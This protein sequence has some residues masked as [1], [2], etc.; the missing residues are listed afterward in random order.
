MSLPP[1]V[2]GLL[3]GATEWVGFPS[4]EMMAKGIGYLLGCHNHNFVVL[5]DHTFSLVVSKTALQCL[6]D[7]FPTSLLERTHPGD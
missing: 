4:R 2:A 1:D 5:S 6:Q 7:A 3:D